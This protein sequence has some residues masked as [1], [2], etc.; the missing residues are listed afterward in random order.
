MITFEA[1]EKMCTKDV[2]VSKTSNPNVT[3]KN[4]PLGKRREET[5]LIS[6]DIEWIPSRRYRTP[7]YQ[8]EG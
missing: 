4:F 1:A 2:F 7:S 8:R 5:N 6:L 3:N